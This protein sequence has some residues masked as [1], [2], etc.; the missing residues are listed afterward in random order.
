[1][2][3]LTA[4][5]AALAAPVLLAQTPL[6]YQGEDFSARVGAL[7]QFQLQSNTDP[8]LSGTSDN[9]VV[10]RIRIYA[11]GTVGKDIE[12]RVDTDDANQ[13]KVAGDTSGTKNLSNLYIQDAYVTVLVAPSFKLDTGI[14]VVDPSHHATIGAT[15]LY[16]WDT[17]SYQGLQNTALQNTS[18]TAPNSREVGTQA[19]GLL[20]G[21]FL[22]YHLALTNGYRNGANDTGAASGGNTGTGV[23]VVPGRTS[24]SSN[25]AFRTTARV[26]F[27]LFDA[28]DAVYTSAGTY[29]GAKKIVT[30]SAGYDTQG[31]YVQRV[32]E[33]FVDLPVNGGKDVFTLEGSYWQY[34][35]GTFLPSLLRQKDFSFQA[36]YNFGKRWN[37]IFRLETRRLAT[38]GDASLLTPLKGAAWQTTPT[39]FNEDRQSLGVA[40]WFHQHNANLKV[41]YTRVQPVNE[42]STAGVNSGYRTY[43][44]AVAQLQIYAY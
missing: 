35:G 34:D 1:M 31:D 40:Y 20:L 44:Q 19:R 38:P 41:F 36:G 8:V 18:A 43:H 42:L 39:A 27:N 26:Q 23:T 17:F 37:P 21:G 28:E 2:Q 14:I 7:A 30:F 12:Y 9:F 11:G 10:R 13:G 16:A 33:V 24:T 22:E 15:R 32:G 6:A 3:R 29:F 4:S 25:N 5:I